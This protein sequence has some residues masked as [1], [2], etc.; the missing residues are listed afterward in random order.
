MHIDGKTNLSDVG[1]KP[2]DRTTAAMP[3]LIDLIQHGI[4]EPK[5]S[6]D[7]DKTFA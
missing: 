2:N 5:R 4:H 6:K 3:A 1:T 7:Y